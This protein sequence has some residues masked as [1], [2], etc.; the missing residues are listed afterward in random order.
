META[1]GVVIGTNIGP[2]IPLP[3]LNLGISS[4]ISEKMVETRVIEVGSTI[5][6]TMVSDLALFG[7]SSIN[8]DLARKAG[9][10]VLADVLGELAV[11]MIENKPFSYL[12]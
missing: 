6:G 3:H 1:T 4:T 8:S 7:N 10:V 9:I 12:A 2:L 11:D 5:V